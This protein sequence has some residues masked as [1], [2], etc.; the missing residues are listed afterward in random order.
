MTTKRKALSKRTRFEVFKRDSFK[1]Q[2]CGKG[3]PDVILHVDHLSPVSKGGGAD[4]LNLVTSCI[5]CNSGKSNIELSD[6]TA[7]EKQR[8]QLEELNERRDQMEMM[9]KWRSGLATL[10]DQAISAAVDAWNERIVGYHLNETGI[11]SMRKYVQKHGLQKTLDAIDIAA[12]SY[13]RFDDDGG[14]V[15]ESCSLA[16]RKVGGILRMNDK[17]EWL[18]Q[19][20][21]IR[22]ILRNRVYLSDFAATAVMVDMENAIQVG[23]DVEDIK[24]AAC[25]ARYIS[26]F[27]SWLHDSINE[28]LGDG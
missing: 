12:D 19:L 22:G 21:Y 16:L 8:K 11:N 15:P 5:D 7:I 9:L 4:L 24:R 10:E 18:R 20:Y 27:Q 28:V 17:P 2:Y 6:K 1:C 13:F 14:L 25:Q 3:S 26:H 23:I